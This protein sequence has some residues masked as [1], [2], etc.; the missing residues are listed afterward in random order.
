MSLGEPQTLE[1]KSITSNNQEK[2]IKT[3]K[4]P[5]RDDKNNVAG[6][7]GIAIDITEYKDNQEK[8]YQSQQLLQ[9]VLDTIPQL[10]FWKDR[11]LNY[12][13]CNQEF[14]KI[15]G[16]LSSQEIIGKTDHEMPWKQEETDFYIECDRR[17]MSSGRAELGI[18]ETQLT[19]DGKETYV[20]TNKSPLLDAEGKVIGILGTVQ[21]VTLKKEAE[22]TLKRINEELEERVLERTSALAKIN[23]DLEQAK[24]CLLYTSPSPRDRTRSRMPSSA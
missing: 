1:E 22:K 20:E 5:F 19:A 7:V 6:T 8:L 12:L 3:Y 14:A 13:G 10:V 17:I 24:D 15:A 18:I 2:W 9:L 4:A 11:N 23:H 21:D 16:L